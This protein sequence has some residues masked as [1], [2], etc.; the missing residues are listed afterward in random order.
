MKFALLLFGLLFASKSMAFDPKE[1]IDSLQQE[2]EPTLILAGLQQLKEDNETFITQL[3]QE[4]SYRPDDLYYALNLKYYLRPI[5]AEMY[6]EN[7]KMFV[8]DSF[9][10]SFEELDPPIDDVWQIVKKI[11]R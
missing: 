7:Y 6:C 11:C 8:A 9:K 10:V 4:K 1:V 2:V 5:K 3:R